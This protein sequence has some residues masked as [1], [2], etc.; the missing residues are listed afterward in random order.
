M[1][2]QY[3]FGY[4]WTIINQKTISNKG[5]RYGRSQTSMHSNNFMNVFMY[6]YF[7]FVFLSVYNIISVIIEQLWT[8]KRYQIRGKDNSPLCFRVGS[9]EKQ[10]TKKELSLAWQQILRGSVPFRPP[11]ALLL[12]PKPPKRPFATTNRSVDRSLAAGD[13]RTA[14]G[15][16]PCHSRVALSSSF[17]LIVNRAAN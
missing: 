11:F 15:S 5:E 4:Y 7:L 17:L 2:L 10:G 6:T 8:K 13:T 1:S 14:N 12:P 16:A 3:Y 9:T